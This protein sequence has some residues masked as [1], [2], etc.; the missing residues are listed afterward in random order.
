MWD[1]LHAAGKHA[2]WKDEPRPLA[3]E[4]VAAMKPGD[5][6][7]ELGCGVGSDARFFASKGLKVLATDFSKEVIEQDKQEGETPEL[8]FA[9]LD[10]SQS[11]SYP[12]QSFEI[13][14]AYLALHYFTG[15]V[16]RNIFKEIHRVLKPGGKVYFTC[17]STTDPLYGQGKQL[18]PD[19]Y[20]CDG[21][22]RHFF[23][24]AYAREILKGHFAIQ[25]LDAIQG[26][27]SGAK[28]HFIQ[29][30]AVKS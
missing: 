3:Q 10:I 16:T 26:D 8:T 21:H 25:K 12:D 4:V 11:F 14:Y 15:V 30:I 1:D 19:M 22:V 18:E 20:E 7:L 23:S 24:E 29:C 28:S 2:Q 6:L 13:V 17:K 5:S 27:Y 9:V